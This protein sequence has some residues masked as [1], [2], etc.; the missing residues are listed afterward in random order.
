MPRRYVCI[1]I[2]A[3]GETVGLMTLT[4][5]AATSQ[6]AFETQ[7]RIAQTCAEQVSLAIANVR[8]RDELHHQ[9]V[10]DPLTGLF[11]RRHMLDALRRM[12]DQRHPGGVALVSIDVDH[13]KRF[14]D[15]HGHDAGDM[16]LRAVAE[17]LARHAGEEGIAC[18]TGGEELMIVLPGLGVGRRAARREVRRDVAALAV[19]YGDSILPRVTISIGVAAHPEHGTMPQEVIRAADDALYAAKER[20]EPGGRGPAARAGRGRPTTRGPPG[21]RA[22]TTPPGLARTAAPDSQPARPARG[23]EATRTG[24]PDPSDG[25]LRRPAAGPR[26]AGQARTPEHPLGIG[27]NAKANRPISSRAQPSKTSVRRDHFSHRN[28]S[29]ARRRAA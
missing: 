21:G 14:N 4:R 24:R 2:L 19:R 13:F 11:N 28:A 1:P 27:P 25:R 18:R 10:R 16:V 5:K 9:A 20:P 29:S 6:E 3:H 8:M 22:A 7:R 26:P 12:I 15:N 17:V 23:R